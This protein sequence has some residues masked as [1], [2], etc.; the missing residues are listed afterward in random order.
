MLEICLCFRS[1]CVCELCF[2]GLSI[3]QCVVRVVG[4]TIRKGVDSRICFIQEDSK[5]ERGNGR[6]FLKG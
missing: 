1:W 3:R 4:V 2:R 6:L 5:H